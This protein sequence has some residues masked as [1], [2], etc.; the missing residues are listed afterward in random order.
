MAFESERR[1]RI[2]DYTVS[3]K[4]ML[5]RSPM[6]PSP[7]ESSENIDIVF[8]GVEY[9]GIPSMMSGVEVRQASD[10][11]AASEALLGMKCD[12]RSLFVLSSGGGRFTVVAAGYKVLRNKLDIFESSLEYFAGSNPDRNLGEVLDHSSLQVGPTVDPQHV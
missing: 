8:W 2:W 9:I 5:V 11:E 3:H 4:Q 7:E 1:F 10:E 6:S 12:S